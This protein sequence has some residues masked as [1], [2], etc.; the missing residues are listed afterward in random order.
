MEK[1]IRSKRLAPTGWQDR[2]WHQQVLQMCNRQL[3]QIQ[4]GN[5]SGR[6]DTTRMEI[7]LSIVAGYG[8]GR[9]SAERLIQSERKWIMDE[10]ISLCPKGRHCPVPLEICS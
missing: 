9:K 5:S 4:Y 3:R 7:A 8:R 10:T 1:I 6:A 2:N